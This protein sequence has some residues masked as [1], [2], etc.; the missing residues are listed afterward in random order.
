MTCTL[1]PE[2]SSPHPSK[3]DQL[4]YNV[5]EKETRCSKHYPDMQNKELIAVC[6]LIY[7]QPVEIRE[8][9]YNYESRHDQIAGSDSVHGQGGSSNMEII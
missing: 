6:G 9:A 2:S 4:Q 8:K 3:I 5:K 1:L 7:A